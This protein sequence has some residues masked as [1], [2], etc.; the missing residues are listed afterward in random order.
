MLHCKTLLVDSDC[1]VIGSANYDQRSFRLNFE[2]C[3][4]IYD[5]GIASQLSEEYERGFSRSKRVT[6]P[7]SVDPLRR[8]AEA[9][10]RLFSPLL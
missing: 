6:R 5:E 2:V 10:A 4:A 1:A 7:R 9:F 3:A 8:L